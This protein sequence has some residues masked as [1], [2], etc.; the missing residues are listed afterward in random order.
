M[1]TSELIDEATSRPVE[2]R[3]KVVDALLQSLNT[4]KTE[5]DE[6]WSDVIQKRRVE[7]ESGTVETISAEAVFSKIRQRQQK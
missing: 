7:V 2:D 6:A 1:K 3:I 5:I 4:P